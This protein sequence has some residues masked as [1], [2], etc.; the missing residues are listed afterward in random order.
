MVKKK[1]YRGF[2]GIVMKLL[3]GLQYVETTLV[4]GALGCAESVGVEGEREARGG[5]CE[6]T[7][8]S[9]IEVHVNSKRATT[10]TLT[11]LLAS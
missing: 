6:V 1:E 7:W 3:G 11:W 8:R 4:G 2:D 10:Q 9:A 5:G